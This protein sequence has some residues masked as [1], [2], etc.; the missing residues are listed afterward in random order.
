MSILIATLVIPILQARRR[1]LAQGVRR[2][3]VRMSV[4]IAV[5]TLAC[6]YVY[7]HL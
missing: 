5:W 7:W 1:N 3:I 6:V 2:T 4:F